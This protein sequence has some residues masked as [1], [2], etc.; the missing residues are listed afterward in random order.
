MGHVLRELW[1]RRSRDV[2]THAAYESLGGVGGALS[3]SADGLLATFTSDEQARIRALML[4]LVKRGRGTRDVRSTLPLDEAI[5]L[6]GGG[7]QGH[8]VLTRLSGGRDPRAPAETPAPPRLLAVGQDRVDLVHE[9]LL[10][11]W[12]TLR[13]WIE[14]DRKALERRDDP[15]AAAK[16]W[17]ETGSK[18]EHLPAAEQLAHL[19]SA[20]VVSEAARAFLRAAEVRE[21]QRQ[22]AARRRRNLGRALIAVSIL[23][24]IAVA[25]LFRLQAKREAEFA[26][27][28]EERHRNV[29][30]ALLSTGIV[31]T[32]QSQF[33][34]N[35]PRLSLRLLL[36]ASRIVPAEYG[37]SLQEHALL[38]WYRQPRRADLRG[39][40][41]AVKL[42]AFSPDGRRVV[43]ASTDGTARVWDASSGKFIAP[44]RGHSG[45][46]LK[47]AFSPDGLRVI[48]AS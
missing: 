45:W 18:P 48:T 4:G 40:L 28:Q 43:T 22:Q 12:S 19:R 38:D 31:Q 9:A 5:A 16:L 2:L 46:V 21:G 30:R 29:G 15:E 35:D 10:E 37:T 36:E 13:G 34:V 14:Q 8:Q 47:A 44:L 42:A 24:P 11:Q 27:E 3:R 32:V 23:A 1:E 17:R 26:Q 41:D 33:D 20:Q 7:E 6:A 25:N 39:H